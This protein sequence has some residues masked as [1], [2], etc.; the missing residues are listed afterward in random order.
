VEK[1][2][3]LPLALRSCHQD[4]EG[5]PR[6]S[7]TTEILPGVPLLHWSS[8]PVCLWHSD[9]SSASL[10]DHP[11]PYMRIPICSIRIRYTDCPSLIYNQRE[12]LTKKIG[13]IRKVQI[14]Y[15]SAQGDRR[16][17]LILP[18]AFVLCRAD[19]CGML[20]RLPEPGVRLDE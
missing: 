18:W 10:F 17:F 19:L 9:P 1:Y 20:C 2:K 8:G 13:K 12:L 7:I 5:V 3:N 11:R 16:R 15:P 6:I 4:N 14:Q